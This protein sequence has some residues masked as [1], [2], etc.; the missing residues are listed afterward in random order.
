MA[1]LKG[2]G[3]HLG[4]LRMVQSSPSQCIVEVDLNKMPAGQVVSV[5]IHEFGDISEGAVRYVVIVS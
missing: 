1:I 3:E 4:L 2:P 5:N